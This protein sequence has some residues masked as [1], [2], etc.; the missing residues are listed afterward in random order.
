MLASDQAASELAIPA[1][2]ARVLARRVALPALLAAVVFAILLLSGGPLEAFA[3]ALRRGM[4]A[5]PGW[6]VLGV[7]FETI[8]L[9]GYVALLSLVAGR[10]TPRIGARESAQITLAGAAA[11]RVLPTAGAG[12]AALAVWVLRRAGL[13]PLAAART[14][15]SFMVVLYGV[16]LAAIAITGGVLALG[17]VHTPGPEALSAIPAGGAL[18]GIGLCLL[19]ACRHGGSASREVASSGVRSRLKQAAGV[20]GH[21]VRDALELIGSRD[22]RL[23]GAVAYWLFDAAVLW[24]MLHALGSSPAPGVVLLAYLVGQVANTVPIPGSVSGG[25]VGVLVAF[26]APLAIALPAVL[27]YRLIS[28]WIPFPAAV[29]AVPKLRVTLR[30][31]AREDALGHEDDR[32]HDETQGNEHDGA[33]E[34]ASARVQP[35]PRGD[36]AAAGRLGGHRELVPA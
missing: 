30:R 34:G 18:L 6:L 11:T 16:F 20:V 31:W 26:G 13:R 14:L 1:P 12:G 24:S 8:S 3:K 21:G 4:A 33:D 27:A 2:D 23:G 15:L 25:V 17:L 19:L 36:L 9:V 28:V 5:G 32:V 29:A 10:A 35:P 7:A 22:P